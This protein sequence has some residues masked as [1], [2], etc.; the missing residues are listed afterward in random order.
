MTAKNAELTL[1][2]VFIRRESAHNAANEFVLFAATNF[3]KEKNIKKNVGF[4]A[5]KENIL[6]ILKNIVNKW[7]I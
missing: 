3:L 2:M 6:R 7:E 4:A 1:E 5:K